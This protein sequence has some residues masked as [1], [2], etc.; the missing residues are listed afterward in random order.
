MKYEKTNKYNVTIII[1]CWN[2]FKYTKLCIESIQKHTKQP[3]QLI[4]VD[5]GSQDS[6]PK[7][8]KRTFNNGS[9][10]FIRNSKN[11]GFSCGNN[12]ALKLAE[13]KYVLMVNND[14]EVLED[15]WLDLMVDANISAEIVG[16]V[17][18]KVRPN[19]QAKRFEY[20][21][22]G[23][24]DETWSYI[25]GWCLFAK[26]DV[27]L[28]LDG[29]DE[30][31][32]PAFSEDADLSFRAKELGMKIKAVS[33]PIVHHG[34]KSIGQIHGGPEA[35]SAKNNRLLFEKWITKSVKTINI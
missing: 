14:C 15:D 26:K 33:L 29:F 32:N 25:E 7:Y 18:K 28:M 13:C 5:Q 20:I 1:L 2:N 19:Y 16:A 3:Y 24:E 31:F 8:L 22:D 35:M 4:A 34:S 27:W 9:N 12:Q 30:R 10:L 11:R 21:G 6:T 17:C 23:K